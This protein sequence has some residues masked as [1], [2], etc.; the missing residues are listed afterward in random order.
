MKRFFTITATV[1]MFATFA[2]AEEKIDGTFVATLATEKVCDAKCEAGECAAGCPIQAAMDALPKFTYQVGTEKTCCSEA[3]AKLAKE[4]DAPIHFVLSDKKFETKSVALVALAEATEKYVAAFATPKTCSVSGKTT[5]AGK[6]L[7][8][9]VMAGQ[10]AKLAK[11]AMAKVNMTYL[12]GK[13]ACNCPNEAASLAK[14]SGDEQLF[15]VGK[16]K[17]CCS[18]TARLTLARAKYRAA[19]EA[20]AKADAPADTDKS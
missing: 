19:V 17:T 2:Q 1:L 14:T 10:R 6:E 18:T 5:V 16:E 13:Q 4:H 3:A 15:V 9:D 12:V 20:L 8:C 7:C 11:D